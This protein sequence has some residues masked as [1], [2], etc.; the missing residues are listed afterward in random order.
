MKRN[1][2]RSS[3]CLNVSFTIFCICLA[4]AAVV[5]VLLRDC[6]R[7]GLC[8]MDSAA[9]LLPGIQETWDCKPGSSASTLC[10]VC[11]KRKCQK[12]LFRASPKTLP[13]NCM[14]DCIQLRL[15]NSGS[16]DWS[17]NSSSAGFAAC[18][19]GLRSATGSSGCS[20][21]STESTWSLANTKASL[22]CSVESNSSGSRDCTVASSAYSLDSM[23]CSSEC[24]AEKIKGLSISRT[25]DVFGETYRWRASH[26]IRT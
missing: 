20:W 17:A 9:G 6:W 23:G 16:S 7:P 24:G 14:L 21:D 8:K 26:V 19:E 4:A 22:D 10:S 3:K 12:I 11:V 5:A 2:F 15:V 13:L 1:M 25:R 18:T